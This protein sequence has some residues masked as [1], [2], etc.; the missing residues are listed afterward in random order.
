MPPIQ[1]HDGDQGP[2][3]GT[4]EAGRVLANFVVG[5]RLKQIPARRK[6]LLVVLEWLAESFERGARYPEREVN[7]RLFRH[8]PDFAML[9]RLLVDYGFLDRDHGIYWRTEAAT[10]ADPGAQARMATIGNDL[11]ETR[12]VSQWYAMLFPTEEESAR[13]SA[14]LCVLA[15]RT[16]G[17]V[18]SS[19]HLTIGYFIGD[20][21]PTAVVEAASALARPSILVRAAE[22][23]SWSEEQD[24]VNGYTLS[25][26]VVRDDGVRDWQRR[27]IDALARAGLTPTFPWEDQNPHMMVLRDLPAPPAEVLARLGD[28][29]FAC[30]FMASRLVISQRLDGQFVILLDK[31]LSDI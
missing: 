30:E 6:K 2:G 19:A 24:P 10:A 15:N 25:L 7:E 4:T 5:E 27:A 16:G 3:G 1:G 17:E 20:A 22:L 18:Y 14:R 13:L 8:H 31:P 23:F 21:N 26:Q 9:R 11:E 12:P 28:Q 29:E